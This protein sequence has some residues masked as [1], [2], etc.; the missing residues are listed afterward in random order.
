[1]CR[2]RRVAWLYWPLRYLRGRSCK[3]WCRRRSRSW[4]ATRQNRANLLS[5]RRDQQHHNGIYNWSYMLVLI[6]FLRNFNELSCSIKHY[7]CEAKLKCIWNTAIRKW[8]STSRNWQQLN[9]WNKLGNCKLAFSRKWE[10]TW[11]W[12]RYY[13]AVRS[14]GSFC[15]YRNRS[16]ISSTKKNAR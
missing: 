8:P 6:R 14:A 11:R 12:K 9:S 15:L 5:L 3:W 2:P 13:G 10:S 4:R 16:L 1:M 7:E